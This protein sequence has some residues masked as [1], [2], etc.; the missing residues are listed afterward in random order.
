MWKLSDY[1]VMISPIR[2]KYA[3]HTWNLGQKIGSSHIKQSKLS[4]SGPCWNVNQIERME[5]EIKSPKMMEENYFF[6]FSQEKICG[7]RPSFIFH[8][9]R[10]SIEGKFKFFES[11]GKQ[12]SRRKAF[13]FSKLQRSSNMDQSSNWSYYRSLTKLHFEARQQRPLQGLKSSKLYY[14]SFQAF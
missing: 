12:S 1:S 2:P 4:K 7:Q 9:F 13:R 6:D 14:C 10:F 5:F 8:F 11:V 3:I